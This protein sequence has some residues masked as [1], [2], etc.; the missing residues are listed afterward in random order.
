MTVRG[1]RAVR[2]P[3][4][5]LQSIRKFVILS[6][7]HWGAFAESQV[8]MSKTRFSDGLLQITYDQN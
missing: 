4:P 5:D 6:R 8:S 2:P 7:R 3:A 1:C